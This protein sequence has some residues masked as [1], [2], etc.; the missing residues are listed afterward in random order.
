MKTSKQL[1][2]ERAAISDK[3]ESLSKIEGRTEAHT[4][5]LTEAIEAETRM[6]VEIEAQLA[7]EKREAEKAAA[8]ARKAGSGNPLKNNAGEEKEL[9]KFSLSKLILDASGAPESRGADFEIEVL[10]SFG[11]E[12]EVIVAGEQ[13]KE[14]K[15]NPNSRS[16]TL[17]EKL[18]NVMSEKRTSANATTAAEGA[19]FVQTDK[20]GFFDQLFNDSV[21]PK[22]GVQHLTGLSSNVDLR[23]FSSGYTSAWAAEEG[24]QNTSMPVTV[25]RSLTPNLLYTAGDATRRILM[26]SL[27]SF[28]QFML[29]NMQKSMAQ[30]IEQGFVN[31]TGSDQMLGILSTSNIQDVA[32][33][34]TG[35]APS[36]AKVLDLITA[37]MQAG[38]GSNHKFLTN[39]KVVNKLK[40]TAIDT[41]SGGMVMG[42]NN[43]FGS[44]MGV[45]DGYPVFAT[46]N[47]PSNLDKSTSTGICSALIFGDF[48]QVV[49]AHFGAV[50]LIVDPYTGARSG[51]VKYTFNQSL[52]QTIMQPGLLGAILD[53]LT[54]G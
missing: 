19:N 50:E 52:D 13:R 17:P 39:W 1:K 12:E 20:I 51:V 53:I 41:P 2:E 27:P 16:F 28:D 9:R 44:D 22:L 23:G 35:A 30:K 33:G 42:Y 26:Q 15:L 49:I 8:E 32:M 43:L 25:V 18:L 7:I 3:I 29:T 38:A 24:T 4:K 46:A 45:I 6:G 48:S 31:G 54:T 37:V 40:R 11:K 14:R 21:L 34:A 47:V 36:Y 10:E 5:E